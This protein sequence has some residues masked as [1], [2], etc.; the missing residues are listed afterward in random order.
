MLE[1]LTK[2]TA[3]SH[4]S[5]RILGVRVDVL[6]REEMENTILSVVRNG[7]RGW[8]CYVNIHTLQLAQEIPW[9]K[10]FIDDARVA[11]CDGEGVRLGAWLL[12][13]RL[14][15]RITL[16]TYLDELA[17]LAEKEKLGLYF[18]GAT[19]EVLRQGMSVLQQRFPSL[20]ILG[21][22]DG[23]FTK[24]EE[25]DVLR[26]INEKKPHILLIGMGAPKQEQWVKENFRR[27]EVPLVWVGGGF[28]DTLAGE[29]RICPR[30][31]ANIGMEWLFRLLQ[32]PRRLW[33]RYLLGNP[34]FF[35]EILKS[36]IASTDNNLLR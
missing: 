20:R 24:D 35:W 31:L 9:Y 5:V 10:K 1:T 16:T 33:R 14:P 34:R 27:L 30:W 11:Y 28:L 32:E 18:L 19:P 25:P 26:E 12:G 17:A 8:F 7:E 6:T 36:K 23:Y 2:S 15:E 29:K 22:R 4:R 21:W 13:H 3:E